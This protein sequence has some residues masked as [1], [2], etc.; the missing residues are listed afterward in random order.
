MTEP[1]VGHHGSAASGDGAP[2][3][4]KVVAGLAV[5]QLG[6]FVGVL[7]PVTVSMA[8]KMQ[9]LFPDS[10]KASASS[11]A[12][13]LSVG[14]IV[15]M[16][17]SPVFGRISDRTTSRF[18]RRRP[19][20][21]GGA[22]AFLA[23]LTGVAWGPSVPVVL[24]S[25]AFCQ[26][27]VSCSFAAL[28]ASL[29]DLVP[30]AQRGRV[31]GVLGAMANAAPLAGAYLA[32]LFTEDMALLFLVPGVIAALSVL[33]C[34]LVLPDRPI[35][36]APPRLGFAYF[37]RSFWVSPH[38][39]PDFA[40]VWLG[41]FLITLASFMFITFRLYFLQEELD[42]SAA[43]AAAVLANGVLIYTVG[44]VAASYVGGRLSDRLGRRRI[45]VA[46][47]TVIFSAGLVALASVT[48]IGQFYVVEAIMGIAFGVYV[49]VDMALVIDVLPDPDEA[50][51]DLGVFNIAN[52][53]PQS[54]ASG[55][56][57]F[58][59]TLGTSGATDNYPALF[60]GA[61]IVGAVGAVLVMFVRS[62][63]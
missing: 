32:P 5:A 54:L 33:A 41:R 12:A 7:A 56:G 13:V 43:E 55:A 63:R 62:V 35:A 36:T 34:V 22:V 39:H 1:L 46:V 51:K 60:W 21:L 2:V 50:A 8:I 38:K 19:W 10:A 28:M 59:L 25:W 29:A 57:L 42:M 11:L 14:A 4:G 23:G 58:L 49:G 37:V 52:A 44:L 16:V 61:G 17:G 3:P 40:L 45:F 27:C 6:L 48:T 20:L 15:A 18:G 30:L 47:A 26:L 9:T 24:V 31:S 53:L